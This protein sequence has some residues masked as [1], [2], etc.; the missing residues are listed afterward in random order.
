MLR[1]FLQQFTEFPLSSQ[2][3][4]SGLVLYLL[5]PP[6]AIPNMPPHR[7][8][9]IKPLVTPLRE[10]LLHVIGNLARAHSKHLGEFF[11]G[12]SGG[13]IWGPTPLRDGMATL[14]GYKAGVSNNV[15]SNLTK[16]SGTNLSAIIFGNWRDLIV[17]QWGGID[18]QAD[19]YTAGDEG[20]VIVR[21]F[22]DVDVA[23][24]HAASFSAMQDSITV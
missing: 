7:I 2:L 23:L 10:S 3:Q 1:L 17:G 19:P 8:G 6:V 13:P 15:P 14:N 24:R 20:A 4:F 9:D 12:T 16:G 18:L 22:V 11:S 21:V 5:P